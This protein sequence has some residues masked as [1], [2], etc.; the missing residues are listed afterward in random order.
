MDKKPRPA[1]TRRDDIVKKHPSEVVKAGDEV[2]AYVLRVDKER[3]RIGLSLRLMQP[4]PWDAV[5]QNYS[6]GQLVTGVITKLTDFG[7]FAALDD[8]IEGLIHISELAEVPPRHP[9][10]VVTPDQAVPLIVVK[11]DSRRRR[12]GLSLKRVSEEE[13]LDWEEQRKAA[14]EPEEVEAAEAP[15]LEGTGA[16]ASLAEEPQPEEAEETTPAAE[17]PSVELPDEILMNVPPP[18]EVEAPPLADHA[19]SAAPPEGIPLEEPPPEE[20]EFV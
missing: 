9:S 5:E 10:E 6:V 1:H 7:A 14:A 11:I 16:R 4:D 19:P 13:W 17:V 15:V 18:E 8:G 20:D 3:K 12:M 2:D